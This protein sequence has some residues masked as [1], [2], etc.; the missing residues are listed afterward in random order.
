[1]AQRIEGTVYELYHSGY[2][3]TFVS[4]T[5]LT[6]LFSFIAE[7]SIAGHTIRAVYECKKDVTALQVCFA[8]ND[9]YKRILYNLKNEKNPE[10]T[11]V[12]GIPCKIWKVKDGA[13]NRTFAYRYTVPGWDECT[14]IGLRETKRVISARLDTSVRNTLGLDRPKIFRLNIVRNGY[15]EVEATTDEEALKLGKELTETDFDWEDVDQSV[16][17]DIAIVE[18]F[19][20][21]D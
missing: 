3:R 15:A 11:I 19:T 4:A 17:E 1:M 5:S 21:I 18:E 7:E 16:L 13:G 10:D 6:D 8:E 20:P 14:T 12:L 9:L 2:G